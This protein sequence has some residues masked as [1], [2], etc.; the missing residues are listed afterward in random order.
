M[1]SI[2]ESMRF[3]T[4]RDYLAYIDGLPEETSNPYSPTARPPELNDQQSPENT[5]DS[6][7]LRRDMR[8]TDLFH[9]D[10][11]QLPEGVELPINDYRK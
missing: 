3:K 4:T 8:G 2:G 1:T 11:V 10:K 9:L 6:Q 7:R 5:G